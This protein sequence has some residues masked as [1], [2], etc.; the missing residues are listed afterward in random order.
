MNSFDFMLFIWPIIAVVVGL[1]VGFAI[2]S[3][4][5]WAKRQAKHSLKQA[6]QG[7]GF[8][9]E[10]SNKALKMLSLMEDNESRRLYD[11]LTEL[12]ENN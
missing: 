1:S 6:N 7:L 4:R 3:N 12:L 2:Y 11:Q 9:R 8:N 10:A 5:N